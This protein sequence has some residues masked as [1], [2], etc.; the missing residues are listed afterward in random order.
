MTR[1]FVNPAPGVPGIVVLP[2]G[3]YRRAR[4]TIS[5]GAG[6]A[7]TKLIDALALARAAGVRAVAIKDEAGRGLLGGAYAVGEIV[8][9]TLARQGIMA[10]ALTVTCAGGYHGRSIAWGA[11]RAGVRCVVFVPASA[12]A[13]DVKTIEAL[14]AEVR[15][16]GA[17]V[18]ESLRAA[19]EAA[20]REGWLLVADTSWPGYTEVPRSVMQGHRLM[21]DEALDQWLGE[22]PTHVF[23]QAGVGGLAAAAAVQLRARL[24]VMPRL[25]V[26]EPEGAAC[27]L[28]SAER[29]EATVLD[30][31]FE[32][33]MASL[34]RG[35]PSLL[36]WQ[37]LARSACAFVAISDAAALDAV[38]RLAG[39]GVSSSASGAAGLGGLLS[40]AGDAGLREAIGLD[41]A[42]AVLLFNTEGAV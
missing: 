28:E 21:V 41:G 17:T 4:A 34:A 22:P 32:T 18:D 31:P 29:G 1:S 19:R 6:Y 38:G 24:A 15:W 8:A 7:P 9:N 33:V 14:G 42:S 3:G 12:G 30:G 39:L 36:A 16:A 40:V 10:E 2:S 26:V 27:L 37:E 20:D 13:P 35:E 5:G 11:R 25:V 23:V